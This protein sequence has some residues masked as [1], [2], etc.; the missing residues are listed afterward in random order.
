MMLWSSIVTVLLALNGFLLLS[1]VSAGI[2]AF[3]KSLKLLATLKERY[4]DIVKGLDMTGWNSFR[5]MKLIDSGVCDHDA[6]IASLKGAI[7][8]SQRIAMLSVLCCFLGFVVLGLYTLWY[9]AKE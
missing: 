3:L 2:Y 5:A 8:M 7:R 4:P 1:A 6:Q 9:G